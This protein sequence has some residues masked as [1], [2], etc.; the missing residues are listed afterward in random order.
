MDEITLD[1][2]NKQRIQK[3]L[4]RDGNLHQYEYNENDI[5]LLENEGILTERLAKRVF[6]SLMNDSQTTRDVVTPNGELKDELETRFQKFDKIPKPEQYERYGYYDNSYNN[7]EL[8]EMYSHMKTCFEVREIGQKYYKC[9]DLRTIAGT[10]M[11]SINSMDRYQISLGADAKEE[12]SIIQRELGDL[13]KQETTDIE[14]F[15]NRIDKYNEYATQVWNNYL[16]DVNHEDSIVFRNLVHNTGLE[17]KGDFAS[18]YM[19]TSLMT[20]NMM[21]VYGT[22]RT[23]LI[24]KP[25]HIISASYKD[26]Y[27]NNYKNEEELFKSGQAIMLPQEIEEICM[28]ETERLNGE[29]L[30]NENVNIYPEIVV[31]DYEIQGIYYVT[32]GEGELNANYDRVKRMA[33]EK[34]VLLVERDISELRKQKGLEPMTENSKKF[35]CK[36]ILSRCCEKDKDLYAR[37]L[38]MEKIFVDRHYEEFY[39]KYMKLKE[40]SYTK[41]DILKVF[42]DIAREDRQFMDVSES[43]YKRYSNEQG[44][45]LRWIRDGEDL[46]HRLEQVVSDGIFYGSSQDEEKVKK[47]MKI[48]E[49]VPNFDKFKEVYLNLRREGIEDRLYVGI[50]FDNLSYD[51]LTQR[52]EKILEE[53]EQAKSVKEEAKSVGAEPNV[54]EVPEAT[55]IKVP[56][57][58]EMLETDTEKAL[59]VVEMPEVSSNI[60]KGAGD[61]IKENYEINEFGEII[62]EGNTS[63][64][65]KSVEHSTYEDMYHKE[66]VTDLGKKNNEEYIRKTDLWLD[67][68]KG[69]YTSIDK[70]PKEIKAK[71]VKMRSDI[72]SAIGNRVR[73]NN[74]DIDLDKRR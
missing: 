59:D 45:K 29:I 28:K 16:T 35:F 27:T 8:Q 39:E 23:G 42:A 22:I 1:E 48:K 21:G 43:I 68:F 25:K 26:T 72:I 53:Q 50:D 31:D 37:V 14:G 13:L 36:N 40:C 41:E 38:K 20:D 61:E 46:Q 44:Y 71:L 12:L 51:E 52:A 19:S 56:D 57:V 69:W 58:V 32:N 63:E 17:I 24:I 54:I 49:E 7:M 67:R 30:N 70:S 18:K 10:V 4:K 64:S 65:D 6:V 9:K 34:G 66:Q 33:E 62:R 15:K 3:Y 11:N 74:K 47:F 2:L 73:L 60:Y 55:E 5:Q